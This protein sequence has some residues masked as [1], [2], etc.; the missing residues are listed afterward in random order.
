MADGPFLRAATEAKLLRS[1]NH[2]GASCG[3]GSESGRTLASAM[4]T[5]QLTAQSGQKSMFCKMPRSRKPLHGFPK[6]MLD[7]SSNWP[8]TYGLR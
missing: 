3:S 1:R 7:R 8:Y 4:T 2:E 6:A 5:A